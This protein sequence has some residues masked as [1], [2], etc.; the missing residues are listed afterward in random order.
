LRAYR[1][2]AAAVSNAALMSV[3]GN[4]RTMPCDT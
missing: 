2:I 4:G 3:A 1:V